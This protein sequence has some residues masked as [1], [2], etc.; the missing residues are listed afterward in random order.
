MLDLSNENTR[1]NLHIDNFLKE[2]ESLREIL[3]HKDNELESKNEAIR[4]YCQTIEELARKE[5]EEK[6]ANIEEQ[7]M[8]T[9]R[10]D[11]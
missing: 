2:L 8:K 6:R 7:Y 4:N 5:N 11:E 10:I 1:L 9:P 3:S